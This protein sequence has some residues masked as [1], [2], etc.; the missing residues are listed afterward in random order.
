M[1]N[2]ESWRAEDFEALLKHGSDRRGGRRVALHHLG[3]PNTRYLL[4]TNADGRGVARA[5]DDIA[6]EP[7]PHLRTV[8]PG[9]IC[10]PELHR[11][12]SVLT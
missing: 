10:A 5:V 6:N 12:R 7:P 3:E 4:V 8:H 11:L 9:Y 2:G 1:D